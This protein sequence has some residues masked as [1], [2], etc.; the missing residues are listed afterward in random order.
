MTISEALQAAGVRVK[1]LEWE[2]GKQSA[3]AH[4]MGFVYYIAH[5][6]DGWRWFRVI[7]KDLNEVSE[8]P[9]PTREA[10]K[11]AAQADY[12]ARIL[13]ALEMTK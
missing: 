4:G 5:D 10:A 13:A 12:E 7:G 8:S 6:F 3:V 9:S 11:A 1:Q 2:D